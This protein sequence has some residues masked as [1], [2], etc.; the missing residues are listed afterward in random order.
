MGR[1]V[2]HLVQKPWA[3]P[4][5]HLIELFTSHLQ[6][7]PC[8]QLYHPSGFCCLSCRHTSHLAFACSL[9]Q[10][11]SHCTISKAK[12]RCLWGSFAPCC[13]LALPVL[14]SFSRLSANVACRLHWLSCSILCPRGAAQPFIP[15]STHLSVKFS[16]V[17]SETQWPW[18][19][20]N[21][22]MGLFGRYDSKALFRAQISSPGDYRVSNTQIG[23]SR[24][25][26]AHAGRNSSRGSEFKEMFRL[27][28]CP[29]ACAAACSSL[30]QETYSSLLTAP[31]LF[32]ASLSISIY[33]AAILVLCLQ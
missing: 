23:V 11:F 28:Q 13:L 10:R 8:H 19:G 29:F 6:P 18:Q 15:I 9:A 2:Q 12:H 4:E 32:A 3:W 7:L 33:H 22:K 21:W 14:E 30:Q 16:L 31:V 26:Q 27:N 17:R 5:V 24:C 25:H 1:Q 20:G